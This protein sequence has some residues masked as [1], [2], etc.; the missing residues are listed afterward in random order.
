MIDHLICTGSTL[1]NFT[2]PMKVRAKTYQYATYYI[3]VEGWIKV[4]SLDYTFR[5]LVVKYQFLNML[6]NLL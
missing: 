4:V 5:T 1:K 2:F 3:K 6:N